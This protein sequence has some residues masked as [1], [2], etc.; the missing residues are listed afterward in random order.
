MPIMLLAV[1]CGVL[2]LMLFQWGRI[3]G[4]RLLG[5]FYA[6]AGAAL[7]VVAATRLAGGLGPAGAVIAAA[8]GAVIVLTLARVSGRRDAGDG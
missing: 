4:D 6:V 8:A 7:G 3:T 5:A 1:V 2:G